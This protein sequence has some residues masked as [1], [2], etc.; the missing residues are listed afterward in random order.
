MA[1]QCR[2]RQQHHRRAVV[3]LVGLLF[4]GVGVS[5][6]AFWDARPEEDRPPARSTAPPVSAEATSSTGGSQP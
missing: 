5:A 2:H 3:V 4:L 6:P 1:Q